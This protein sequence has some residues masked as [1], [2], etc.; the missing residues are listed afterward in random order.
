MGIAPRVQVYTQL[1]CNDVLQNPTNFTQSTGIE[2]S[3]IHSLSHILH[4]STLAASTPF[5]SNTRQIQN[6]TSPSALEILTGDDPDSSGNTYL[7]QD[8]CL[9]DPRVQ[10]KA[11]RLQTVL[12]TTMGVLSAFTTSWWGHFG[13]RH[14]RTR[15]LAV[16][17]LGMVLSDMIY[18]LVSLPHSPFA[19]HGFKLLYLAPFAEGFTGGWSTLQAA[20]TAYIS[21][22]TS[23]GSRSYIFSRFTGVFYLGFAIGP[24]LGAFLITHPPSLPFLVHTHAQG[25]KNM[26]PVF[27]VSGLLTL[28]NLFMAIF[29]FP[30]SLSKEQRAARD[31][32]AAEA[33]ASADVV[34]ASTGG[35]AIPTGHVRELEGKE[36]G[37]VGL[38][39]RIVAPL[40]VFA[41]RA[42]VSSGGKVRKDWS[43]TFLALALF[44]Y[45][46]SSVGVTLIFSTLSPHSSFT[47]SCVFFSIAHVY[48]CFYSFI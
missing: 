37:F 13:E 19:Q 36:C 38:V 46:L 10:A 28:I 44:G 15:V 14:G 47:H 40:S 34:D 1:A 48:T 22:C 32:A 17:T 16:A 23:D 4:F 25:L 11:A 41:P 20:T 43:M 45:L 3:G 33:I 27:W 26:T 39:K 29:V 21:D 31:A 5:I 12:M 30:E 2:T 8:R 24:T 18:F 7:S 6:D 9:S 35:V 42:R